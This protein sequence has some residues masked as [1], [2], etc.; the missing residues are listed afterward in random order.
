LEDEIDLIILDI[1]MPGMN[2]RECLKRLKALNSDVKVIFSSG[3]DLTSEVD[4]LK[5]LGA[6]GL[7]QKPYLMTDL[8]KRIR[9]VLNS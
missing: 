7:I 2:G 9:S 1:S 4:A 8:G 5:A 3:H 6:L